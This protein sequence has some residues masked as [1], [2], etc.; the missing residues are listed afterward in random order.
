[1]DFLIYTS[2]FIYSNCNIVLPPNSSIRATHS[3]NPHI[4]ALEN[5]AKLFDEVLKPLQTP[6]TDSKSFVSAT[7]CDGMNFD[8]NSPIENVAL[9]NL[10]E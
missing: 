7:T 2:M 4:L 5:D 3:S 8:H 6:T 9:L 1:M 10:C